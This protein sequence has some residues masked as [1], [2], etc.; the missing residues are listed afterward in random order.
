[1]V[2]TDT[3]RGIFT[4]VVYTEWIFFGLLAVGVLMLRRRADYQPAF[5][6]PAATAFAT[7]F[8]IACAVILINQI[9]TDPLNS[10]IGLLAV[11][12]GLPVYYLAFRAGARRRSIAF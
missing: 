3:Y 4:R 12:A 1:L 2:L 6:M 5:R 10:L 8:V 7:V 11:A 9:V